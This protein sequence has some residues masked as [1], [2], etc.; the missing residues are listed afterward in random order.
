MIPICRNYLSSVCTIFDNIS[1]KH[2]NS[3]SLS[4]FNM[5]MSTRVKKG[6]NSGKVAKYY[7]SLEMSPIRN[8][9]DI[10]G[11][12]NLTCCTRLS[13]LCTWSALFFLQCV[14]I[15]ERNTSCPCGKGS[16]LFDRCVCVLENDWYKFEIFLKKR[17]LDIS[18]EVM[19]ETR[20]SLCQTMSNSIVKDGNILRV[21]GLD[22]RVNWWIPDTS[23]V[24]RARSNV[25]CYYFS[26][27][28]ISNDSEV[29][30]KFPPTRSRHWGA[31]LDLNKNHAGPNEIVITYS[32]LVMNDWSN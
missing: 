31:A 13:Y 30:D 24:A 10:E 18:L 2:L 32:N 11:F 19:N 12:K 5:V 1:Q 16:S 17:N 22:D 23:D 26:I 27:D 7:D 14:D 20:R 4:Q 28:S 29:A 15:S 21:H 8:V 6:L 3:L 9:K 25:K